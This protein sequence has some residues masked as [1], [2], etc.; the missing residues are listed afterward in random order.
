MLRT[1]DLDWDGGYYD[2]AP[3]GRYRGRGYFDRGWPPPSLREV[4][5]RWLRWLCLAAAGLG[6]WAF[7]AYVVGHDD[8]RP[9]LSAQGW[10]TLAAAAL[11][12]AVLSVR[13]YRRGGLAL[14]GTLAEYVV[15]ALLAVLLTLTATG[16]PLPPHPSGQAPKQQ[17]ARA[18]QRATTA[19]KQ[20]AH[21]CP[22]VRQVPAWVACLWRQAQQA[23]QPTP[24][25]KAL[26]LA[27]PP[28]RRT[29]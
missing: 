3:P 20:A 18:G 11:L 8:A 10:T 28:A 23:H 24:K 2:P 12:L 7:V 16:V 19:G 6:A 21:G 4:Q 1:R 5:A 13:Y 15:V 27:V 17:A 9:G 26:S 25:A 22:P 29:P 14:A